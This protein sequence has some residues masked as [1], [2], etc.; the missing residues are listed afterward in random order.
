MV[1]K[2]YHT[3]EVQYLLLHATMETRNKNGL[4]IRYQTHLRVTT[5]FTAIRQNSWQ[6]LECLLWAWASIFPI[7]MFFTSWPKEARYLECLKIFR[8]PM[9]FL[10]FPSPQKKSDISIT[11]CTLCKLRLSHG[12]HYKLSKSIFSSEVSH[13][14][15]WQRISYTLHTSPKNQISGSTINV[16]YVGCNTSTERL[17]CPVKK[18]KKK[19]T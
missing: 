13:E 7:G 5:S 4:K 2:T 11:S 14:L 10:P 19:K 1:A 8:A 9:H 16:P 3:A 17:M 12:F 18:K 6:V 15:S